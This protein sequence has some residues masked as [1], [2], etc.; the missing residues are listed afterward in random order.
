[1]SKICQPHTDIPKDKQMRVWLR[2]GGMQKFSVLFCMPN[3]TSPNKRERWRK[4]VGKFDWE[5]F[6]KL[7]L[8]NYF[9]SFS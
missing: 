9:L 3:L 8:A 4:N 6:L 5:N 7:P 2:G 1:M